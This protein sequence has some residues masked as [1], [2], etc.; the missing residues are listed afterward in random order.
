M[1]GPGRA[2]RARIAAL[3]DHPG[4]RLAAVV[5][6]AGAP[7]LAQVLA[8]PQVDAVLICTPNTLHAAQVRAA[9]EAGKHV[10][11]EFPLASGPDE[12]RALLEL[13]TRE[14][15]VLHVEHIE[16]LGASQQRQRERAREIGRP[17]G[18]E[19]RFTGAADGWI[20]DPARAGSPALCALARLHR[21]VDLFGRA[22][23][24]HAELGRG[25]GGYELRVDLC[26][27]SGGELRLVETRAPGLGRATHW[28]IDCERGRLDDPPP[29]SERGLFRRDLDCFVA[30][31]TSGADPY[32]TPARLVEVLE[33]V[34]EIERTCA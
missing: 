14:R 11:V 33:L 34:A 26:F 32:V 28:S 24:A 16:L 12:A 2:G 20:G 18:G 21:L 15:R 3:E 25:G 30:R 22:R 4:A 7:T 19:L 10:A 9:L 13:A 27:E 23:V 6:R 29:G 31:I 5:R 8:D 17:L 1:V